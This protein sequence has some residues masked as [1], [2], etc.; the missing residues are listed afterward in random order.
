MP[1]LSHL[2]AR[3]VTQV[4]LRGVCT[5][6]HSLFADYTGIPVNAL[7]LGASN[8]DCASG[9]PTSCVAFNVVPGTTYSIQVD[10]WDRQRGT[11]LVYTSDA[12]DDLT[13]SDRCGGHRC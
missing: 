9:E 3:G 11:C 10:G 4:P 1:S 12:A 2:G 7:T 8:D 13:R 5:N 6:F